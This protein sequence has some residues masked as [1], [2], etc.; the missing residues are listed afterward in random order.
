MPKHVLSV[1]Q[2]V[3][4]HG[5]ISRFLN[6]TFDVQIENVDTGPDALDRLR[7]RSYD[8]VLINR[9]LDIDY[10]DGTEILRLIK[11]DP[12][13]AHVPVMIVSNYPEHQQNAV[14]LGAV[15]G[16]GK[17]ELGS[18]DAVSRLEPFLKA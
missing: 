8:L 9:K 7:K 3:P 5:S 14:L 12:Q 6:S 10:S 2:C 17:D 13:L 16:F 15:Y 11:A 4:D 18:S 1:G